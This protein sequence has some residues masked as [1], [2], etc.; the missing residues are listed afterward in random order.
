VFWEGWNLKLHLGPK[1]LDFPQRKDYGACHYSSSGVWTINERK[2]ILHMPVLCTVRP[3]GVDFTE[4]GPYSASHTSIIVVSLLATK[5]FTYQ[6]RCPNTLGNFLS[7]LVTYKR[8]LPCRGPR[9]SCWWLSL[10]D[11]DGQLRSTPNKYTFL[12]VVKQKSILCNY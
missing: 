2:E 8:I 6:I 11:I 3:G 9:Y 10:G 5:G 1:I 12:Q 7:A 4:S